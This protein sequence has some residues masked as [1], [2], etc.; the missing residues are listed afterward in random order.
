MI[1]IK[2]M[3]SFLIFFY[4]GV[5][6]AGILQCVG[7]TST[8]ITINVISDS[9]SRTLNVNG[10]ILKVIGT[11][12]SGKGF[13][14][15]NYINKN[16]MVVYFSMTRDDSGNPILIQYNGVNQEPELYI[17]LACH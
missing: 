17:S 7:M 1:W 3:C 9:D 8:G 10:N 16:G 4:I 13:T 11:T 6:N 12:I 14:T 15:E 5:G 2:I